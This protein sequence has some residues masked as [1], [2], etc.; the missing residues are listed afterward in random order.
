MQEP[1]NIFIGDAN[2]DKDIARE[3]LKGVLRDG[4]A[5]VVFTKADGTERSM[6]CTLSESKIPQE[7]APKGS[8][9]AKS[10]ETLAV[11]D[12]ESQGWRSFRWDSVKSVNFFVGE[13]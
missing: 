8:N 1:K 3:W 5:T 2:V 6:K 7:F 13:S 9:R 11:F 4:E 10:D 12:L